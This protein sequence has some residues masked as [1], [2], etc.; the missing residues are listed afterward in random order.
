MT[1]LDERPC[2][3]AKARQDGPRSTCRSTW[4]AAASGLMI[5]VPSNLA[6]LAVQGVDRLPATAQMVPVLARGGGVRQNLDKMNRLEIVG[7]VTCAALD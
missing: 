2:I 4:T 7:R 6:A 3:P 1:R 5:S